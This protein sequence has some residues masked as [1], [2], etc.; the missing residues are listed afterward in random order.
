M[1]NKLFLEGRLTKDPYVNDKGTVV[2]F[3]LAQDTGY[4]DNKGN[5]ITNFV[6]LKA[7]RGALVKVIGDYC[8]KGD[9]IS[10]EAHATTEYDNDEY[11]TALIVDNMHFLTKYEQKEEP[12]PNSRRR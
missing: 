1:M 2:M 5:R 7:F 6:S 3:T 12:E 8:L 11:S 10:V 9:L 4:K